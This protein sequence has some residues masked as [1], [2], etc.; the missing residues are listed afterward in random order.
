MKLNR[1]KLSL[2]V[3]NALNAGVVLSLAAPGV[4]A[5]QAPAPA[6]A[7]TAQKIEKI[8]VTG[9]RIPREIA[10]SD[11]PVSVITAQDIKFTGLT[12]TSDILNQMPQVTPGQGGN[13]SNGATGIAT[14]DLRGLGSVRTLVLIDGKR[15]PAGSPNQWATNINGIPAPLIQ[16]VEVLSGGASSIY[17]SDAIAGVVNFIMNDHFEGIQLDYNINGYN[18]NQGSF[19]AP[20]VAAREVTNPGQFHVPGNVGWDGTTQN[21]SVTAG[22]T[23]ANGKGNATIFFGYNHVESVLQST[24]DYSAC[25]LAPGATGYVCGGSSTSYPGRFTDFSNYNLTIADAAGNVRA[26]KSATD[27]YNFAPTNYFQRPDERYTFNAFMHYDVTPSIRFYSEFDYMNDQTNSQ[28]APSGAFLQQFTLANP[29]GNP[30]LTQSF[31]D[32]VGLSPTATELPIY[33]GRRNV[34]GGGRQDD[35]NLSNFRIVMGAKGGLFDDTWN[36]DAWWQS[37]RNT[38]QRTYK[39]DFS[40][41]RLARA[42]NVVKDPVT[43]LPACASKVDGTDAACVPYDIFHIGGVTQAALDYLQTPGFQTGYT[44]QTVVGGTMTSDLG[45]AYG[46]RLPWAKDGIGVAVGYEYRS[47]KLTQSVDSAF[48]TGDLAG[49]G[50]PTHG[51]S[52]QF[53]V[54]EVYVEA[55]VPIAQRKDWIYDL[56]MNGA[57][58]YSDYSTGV[59]TN[60]YGIGMDWSPV[61]EVKLRG[62]YQQAVR[63]ANVIELFTPQGFGLYDGGDPC[64]TASPSATLAECARTGVTAAQYGK[65]PDSPA[66]QYNANF[67]GNPDLKPETANTY[68][69]GA[70]WQPMPNLLATVDY[71][72]YKVEDIIGNVNPDTIVNDC[73]TQG[74]LCQYVHRGANGNIWVPG[75]GYTDA[76]NTNL[77]SYKTSGL[78]ISFNYNQPVKD[79]GSFGVNFIGTYVSNFDIVQIPGLGSY[80]CAGLFGPTCGVPVPKWRHRL[81]GTWNTPWYNVTGALTWRYIDSVSLDASS[82]NPLL[83]KPY[84][85]QDKSIGSQSYLDLALQWA[86]DKNWTVRAGVNNILDKDPP[87]VSSTAGTFA[88][89]NGPS[90]FGNGG[91]WPQLYDSLGRTIFFNVTAKF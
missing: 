58:R 66:G 51:V 24:R 71:W 5:Q 4:F 84:F 91:T 1:K 46:W 25:S 30:L 33:I 49:Q 75:S 38:L 61:K 86:I 70:V 48:D 31:K 53:N 21:F 80:D 64:A 9:S 6:D 3:L 59:N 88:N 39:N 76:L 55:R 20:I 62:S 50:G 69:L 63:A 57:Y 73:V 12:S 82:S 16:R 77:G 28:I 43:G 2:A 7:P 74:I 83:S 52:G 78:D 22:S 54:N 36:Y 35:I 67:G 34:E 32:A 15:V 40:V 56:S 14:V 42:F 18:H 47:E 81:Q 17:G 45:Q 8:E 90:S 89:A 87:I 65:I 26:F 44:A 60:S 23:F 27:Q 41:A 13:I 11:S 29:N 85:P 10:E 72:N 19:V 68:T 37:G 79:W